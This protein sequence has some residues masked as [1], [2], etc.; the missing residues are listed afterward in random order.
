MIF[1]VRHITEIH[2]AA[3]IRLARFN[4]RLRP[5]PWPGQR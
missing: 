2:Y 3:L 1:D 5:A 4:L